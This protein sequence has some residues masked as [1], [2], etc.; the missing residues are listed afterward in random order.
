MSRRF[1]KRIQGYTLIG[2]IVLGAILI[3]SFNKVVEQTSRDEFC[4]KC[5][6][7]PHAT[8]SWKQSVH[9]TTA[10]GNITHCVEC[11]L[12]PKGEG[13]LGAKITTGLRD[14]YGAIFKDSASHN[15]E[16]KSRPEHAVK[17]AKDISCVHCHENLFPLA[18]SHKGM[19]AHLYYEQQ[20]EI[21]TSY[22]S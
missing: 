6:V 12:P 10:S 19:D 2:G 17:F 11:H 16:M 14:V 4:N 18:L 5:H 8:S 22:R 3:L 9:Y 13:Y 1:F 15:W 20:Q 7:H 21:Q